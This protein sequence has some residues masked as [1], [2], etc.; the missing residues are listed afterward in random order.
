M[1]DLALSCYSWHYNTAAQLA[2]NIQWSDYHLTVTLYWFPFNLNTAFHCHLVMANISSLQVP[3]VMGAS[4]STCP[5]TK[6]WRLWCRTWTRSIKRRTSKTSFQGV[7]TKL[8]MLCFQGC[9]NFPR[10]DMWAL[11]GIWS[12]QKSIH[13]NNEDCHRYNCK[14]AFWEMK[15]MIADMVPMG[16]SQHPMAMNSL[17]TARL[18]LTCS[19]ASNG[20]EKYAL[21]EDTDTE[22]IIHV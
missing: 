15:L 21:Y 10:A 4:T 18:F 14:L 8:H 17:S 12:I 20:A 13:R 16:Q 22:N 19:S 5:T 3:V 9:F 11:M 6:A 2:L 7:G 1:A